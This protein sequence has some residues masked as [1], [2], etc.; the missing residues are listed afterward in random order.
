M[1]QQSTYQRY[2]AWSLALLF[3]AFWS[4]KTMHLLLVHHHHEAAHPVCEVSH[5]PSSAHIHDER[6]AVEDCTICAFVV[7]VPEL[8]AA[9]L[10]EDMVLQAPVQCKPA[11]YTPP[12]YVKA[13]FDANFRRGPPSLA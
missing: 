1:F 13:T 4:L 9:F 3:S 8:F 5:D 10:M 2:G 7:S 11:M 12:V 6:W